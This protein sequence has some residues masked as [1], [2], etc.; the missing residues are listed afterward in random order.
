MKQRLLKPLI[1]MLM[2]CGLVAPAWA[3]VTV[4]AAASLTNALTDIAKTFEVEQKIPV[5]LSFAASSALA[6]QIEQG[7]PADIFISADTK[8]MDYLDGKGK[9]D[10][11]SIRN[12][13]GNTL[14]L[15]APQGKGFPVE[16]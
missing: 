1:G 14:V 3:D 16:M 13:A 8:W 7:A 6:K 4:L 5:K 11:D 9:I 10:H 15:V 12:L 2:S